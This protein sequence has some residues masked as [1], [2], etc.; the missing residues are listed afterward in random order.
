MRRPPSPSARS[1]SSGSSRP[2][3]RKRA[4]FRDERITMAHGA[5]G[6]ATQTLIEGLFVPAF[7]SPALEA[8]GD[9]G[10]VRGRRRR[11]GDDHRLVRRQADPLPGR[12]D[13]RAGGQRHRQ[14][15]RG[16]RRPPAGAD[17]VARARGGPAGRR[18]ARRGRRDRARPPRRPTSRSSPATPRSSSAATPTRCT[19]AHRLGRRDPRARAVAGRAAPGRPRPA[20]RH[21]RRARHGDHAG[22]R[23]VRAR[24]RR[25]TPTPARCGRRSTRCS[26]RPGRRC[27]AMRDATRGGVASVLNELA[28]ASQRGDARAR[29]GG[30][31]RRRRS[32]GA[33]EILGIDPMYVANE[34]KFVAFVAPEAADARWPRC[35]RCPAAS[36]RRRSAR[37]GPSRP[38][39]CWWRRLSA[40]SG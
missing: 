34:G 17:A 21:D 6:K 19:S 29:V 1:G 16:G 35:A 25:S 32:P 33:S 27:A 15:P 7:G 9:A 12:L 4:K 36:R 38:G 31:G 3:A 40:A 2:P 5:G 39:W 24:R 18:A 13:R 28:R 14:R 8:M 30:A 23:R 20:L 22:A 10:V 37:C 11:A 26:T